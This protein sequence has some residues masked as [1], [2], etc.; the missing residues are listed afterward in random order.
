MPKLR[1]FPR[2]YRWIPLLVLVAAFLVT[3][4]LL[5]GPHAALARARVALAPFVL[6]AAAYVGPLLLPQP[7]ATPGRTVFTIILALVSVVAALLAIPLWLGHGCWAPDLTAFLGYLVSGAA[8]ALFAPF[9]LRWLHKL[10]EGRRNQ[11]AGFFL[12]G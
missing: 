7:A 12:L 5:R 8:L 4:V 1:A 10:P 6:L 11:L 9:S 2:L 3:Q